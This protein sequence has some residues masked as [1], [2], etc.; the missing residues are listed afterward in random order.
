MPA[1]I[2]LISIIVASICLGAVGW[3]I[4]ALLAKFGTA[5]AVTPM[6]T[7]QAIMATVIT[8]SPDQT[9]ILFLV[10]DTLSAAKPALDGC[11]V[12]TFQ[13][14]TSKYYLVGFPLD[15][16]VANTRTLLDYYKAGP[17][18]QDGRRL[19]EE[20]VKIATSGKWIVKYQVVIDR[21]TI[22]KLAD[23]V[24]GVTFNGEA[25]DGPALVQRYVDSTGTDA[26][27]QIKFQGEALTALTESLKQRTWTPE[28]LDEL[29]T[30][31]QQYSP[32]AD[33]LL[34]L[35]K[36]ALPLE[37]ADFVVLPYDPPKN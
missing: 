30:V 32:D 35:A 28:A 21:Q 5:P 6:P 24:G 8:P 33:D 17:T 22:A 3:A 36:Q 26:R 4:G 13:P 7:A 37:Q 16:P 31:Y 18:V 11:W 20:A 23:T 1:K 27:A 12:L 19:V 34:D 29:F 14:G 2:T 25:L 15:T 9:S 10:V